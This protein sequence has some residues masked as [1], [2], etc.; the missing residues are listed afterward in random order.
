M[1]WK[2]LGWRLGYSN[3]CRWHQGTNTFAMQEAIIDDIKEH[4]Y[5]FTGEDQDDIMVVLN[6]GLIHEFSRRGFGHVMAQAHGYDGPMDYTCFAENWGYAGQKVFPDEGRN[7]DKVVAKKVQV[8]VDEC[9]D[10]DNASE[11]AKDVFATLY[12]VDDYQTEEEL[13]AMIDANYNTSWVLD[14]PDEDAG[15][16]DVKLIENDNNFTTYDG[17]IIKAYPRAI[18]KK[19]ADVEAEI[20]DLSD[21]KCKITT[22]DE[23]KHDAVRRTYFSAGEYITLKDKPELRFLDI[24][25]T[26]VVDGQKYLV[27]DIE[28]RQQSEKVTMVYLR[29]HKID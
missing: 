21:C 9:D 3:V 13:M 28:K 5:S 16:W 18:Y 10:W 6:D 1:K 4:G 19:I 14:E 8:W 20:Y 2:V 7:I 29:V 15:D 25:D 27:D 26:V 22:L 23:P 17:G 24:G 12:G 11:F